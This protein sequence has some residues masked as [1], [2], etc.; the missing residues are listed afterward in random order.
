M[1]SYSFKNMT[2][3]I[4]SNSWG[5]KATL[6]FPV[7]ATPYSHRHPYAVTEHIMHLLQGNDLDASSEL[8]FLELEL[9]NVEQQI[10]LL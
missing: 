6:W 8:L 5:F 2:D 3:A 1:A 10:L 9:I 7:L 4:G